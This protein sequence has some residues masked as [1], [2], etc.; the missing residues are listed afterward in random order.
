M[1]PNISVLL[2]LYNVEDFIQESLQSV[3]DQSYDNYE[4]LIVNDGSTDNTI[5]IVEDMLKHNDLK[6]KP[7]IYNFSENKGIPIRANLALEKANGKY[8]AIQ[9]GDDISLYNR[10]E[11]QTKVLENHNNIFAIGG[12]CLKIDEKG[13]NIGRLNPYPLTHLDIVNQIKKFRRNPIANPTAMFRLEKF[14][15]I[16]GYKEDAKIKLVQD[17]ELWTKA[18]KNGFI[19]NNLNMHLVKYRVRSESN[20]VKHK[21]EMIMHHMT[22]WKRFMGY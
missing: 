22:V 17:F 19:L 20:T 9:D 18:I 10:F 4:L 11:I 12:Q 16:C 3:L 5:D 1:N 21:N 8:V 13:N 15:S 6:Y 2:T 14:H 7:K